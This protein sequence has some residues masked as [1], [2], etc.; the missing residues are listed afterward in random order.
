[1][2]DLFA[3]Q[4]TTL[5]FVGNVWECVKCD[6]IRG[7]QRTVQMFMSN[8]IKSHF[9]RKRLSWSLLETHERSFFLVNCFPIKC[10][11]ST[12]GLSTRDAWAPEFFWSN[13]IKSKHWQ[14]VWVYRSLLETHGRSV[15]LVKSGAARKQV[16]WLTISLSGNNTRETYG[17][18]LSI[19]SN[20]G[21]PGK[22]GEE[23]YGSSWCN[24]NGWEYLMQHKKTFSPHADPCLNL[25]IG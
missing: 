14:E 21:L 7:R 8:V 22:I 5:T 3:N 1:M 9:P 13:V 11:R 12:R 23:T 4:A 17:S 10:C 20:K 18:I 15:F 16:T 19:W 6:Q 24:V 25:E 2:I